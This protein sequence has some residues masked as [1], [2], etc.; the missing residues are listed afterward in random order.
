MTEIKDLE[1]LIKNKFMI[2]DLRILLHLYLES[3]GKNGT[4]KND[5]LEYS[6][7]LFL[8]QIL[9]GQGDSN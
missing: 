3:K 9:I 8:Y 6:F 2:V 1:L 7:R 5:W 4:A